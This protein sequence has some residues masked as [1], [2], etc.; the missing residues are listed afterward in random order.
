MSEL[1]AKSTCNSTPSSQANPASYWKVWKTIHALEEKTS[2]LFA[3][4]TLETKERINGDKYDELADEIA[5]VLRYWAHKWAG[6]NSWQSFLNKSS[7]LHEVEES[8]VTIQAL[9]DWLGRSGGFDNVYQQNGSNI[10]VLDVCCGKGVSSMLLTFLAARPKYHS[11][12]KRIRYCVMMDKAKKSQIHWN[13]IEEANQIFHEQQQLTSGSNSIVAFPIEVWDNCN[14]HDDS[15]FDRLNAFE[16]PSICST[17]STDIR[18]HNSTTLQQHHQFAMIGIHLCKTLS[19][20]CI[21]VFN[22]LGTEKAPFLCLAPCCLPRFSYNKSNKSFLHTI[23][24]DLYQTPQERKEFQTLIN[25]RNQAIGR[26][27]QTATKFGNA[28]SA[29]IDTG[30]APCWKCGKLGHFKADCPTVFKDER[31]NVIESSRPPRP[32]N[33]NTVQLNVDLVRDSSKPFETYCQ[34]LKDTVQLEN[35]AKY[36][37]KKNEMTDFVHVDTLTPFFERKPPFKNEELNKESNKKQKVHNGGEDKQ[38]KDAKIHQQ[39]KLME[40]H[41][42]GNAHSGQKVKAPGDES[43][44]E[45]R[46]NMNEKSV[47]ANWNANRKSTWIIC[48]R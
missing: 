43:K 34:L 30:P 5:E 35:A 33:P 23:P 13:H 8:I 16:I 1:C 2:S 32:M 19:P 47:R 15:F 25:L 48:E 29:T 45:T 21:S 6:V 37:Q 27:R 42:I 39:V 9:L 18:D 41:M 7:L 14:I 12:L 40:V 3:T 44:A 4:H 38:R 28:N 26:K 36:I 20:R 31:G 11:K 10:V 24:I 17:T 22:M 46:M